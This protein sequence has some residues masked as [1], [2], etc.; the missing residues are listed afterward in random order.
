MQNQI[1]QLR[2]GNLIN[3]KNI[4]KFEKLIKSQ[5]INKY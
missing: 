4:L 1:L 3:I 5:K 2:E